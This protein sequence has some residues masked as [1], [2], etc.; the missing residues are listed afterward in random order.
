MNLKQMECERS[1]RILRKTAN[2][3]FS[4]RIMLFSFSFLPSKSHS[5]ILHD[6]GPLFLFFESLMINLASCGDRLP[7]FATLK[8]KALIIAFKVKDGSENERD[9]RSE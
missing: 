9:A 2:L 7:E 4:T 3:I 8:K 1:A 6:T 5:F